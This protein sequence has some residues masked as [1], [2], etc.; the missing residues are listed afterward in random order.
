[1]VIIIT[2]N[3]SATLAPKDRA[4]R[5]RQEQSLI[6]SVTGLALKEQDGVFA[7]VK[8]FVP[9]H[10]LSVAVV[11][12]HLAGTFENGFESVLD[13]EATA[14]VCGGVRRSRR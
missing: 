9:N 3:I 10:Y 14:I 1:M 13:L 12:A 11:V 8:S 5:L 6:C 2:T 4:P 7:V